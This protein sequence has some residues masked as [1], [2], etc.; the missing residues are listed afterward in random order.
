MNTDTASFSPIFVATHHKGGTVW[1]NSTFRRICAACDLPFIH[2]N[3]GEPA[4][5]IRPDK[6]E[7]MLSE[8]EAARSA[9]ARQAVLVDYHSTTPDLREMAD[10]R[11]IHL[12]RDPR[13]M[14][15]S[16]IRYHETSDEAW[17]DEA[18]AGLG[19]MTF[20]QKLLSYEA[21]D[22][23]VRFELDTHMGE[24]IERMGAFVQRGDHGR[25]FRTVRYEDLI[26]DEQMTLFHELCVHL[27]LRGMGIVHALRAFWD[28]SLFGGMR[29]VAEAGGH[30]HI[31]DGGVSQWSRQL[32]RSTLELIEDRVGGVI[33]SLGYP[34]GTGS[35]G[36]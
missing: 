4:W 12:V 16:A 24:E 25:V 28:S 5:Q 18:R 34:I 22:D 13:D 27:G 31:R 29:P 9:G 8:L 36:R 33:E 17:L 10:A 7:Y 11:G 26:V 15:I 6:R 30:G 21:Y 23:R 1:L 35:G 20:R 14:L 3:T 2:L 19:G 32:E